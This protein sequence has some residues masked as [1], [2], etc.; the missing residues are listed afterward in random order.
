MIPNYSK[1]PSHLFKH[2]LCK[3]AP[4]HYHQINKYLGNRNLLIFVQHYAH[5]LC[6]IFQLEMEMDYWKYTINGLL[7]SINWL[8]RMPKDLTKRYSINWDHPRT[9]HNIRHRQ[10]LVE[11]KLDRANRELYIHLEQYS[12]YCPTLNKTSLYS[13]AAI[14]TQTLIVVIRNGLQKLHTNFQEKKCLMKFDVEYV[15]LL[16][17]FLD[18]N[19]TEEQVYHE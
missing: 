8:L 16:K 15:N 19:P 7:R 9:E 10:R 18:L 11:N 13:M 1:F 3:A 14:I 12:S 2:L 6:G 5:L 17:A 4:H